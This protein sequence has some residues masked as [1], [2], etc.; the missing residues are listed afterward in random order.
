M[1]RIESKEMNKSVSKRISGVTEFLIIAALAWLNSCAH[2]AG[3]EVISFQL[4][5]IG[6][7]TNDTHHSVD[8]PEFTKGVSVNAAESFSGTEID[9]TYHTF[10]P[11][12]IYASDDLSARARINTYF[13]FHNFSN[14]YSNISTPAEASPPKMSVVLTTFDDNVLEGTLQAID[15]EFILVEASEDSILHIVDRAEVEEML[16][17]ASLD[18]YS[19]HNHGIGEAKLDHIEL[20]NG[21]MIACLVLEVSADTIHYFD[22]QQLRR[23]S[24]QNTSIS[25]VHLKNEFIDYPVSGLAG[26]L[27]SL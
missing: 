10:S 3:T 6:M 13:T 4:T 15:D 5:P 14:S 22:S 23:Q 25:A 26:N 9:L 17:N 24:L 27:S 19:I 1:M 11:S 7:V 18:L 16:M 12:D 2:S 20:E 21:R 8:F